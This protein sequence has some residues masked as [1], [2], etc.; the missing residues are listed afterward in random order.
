MKENYVSDGLKFPFCRNNLKFWR[1]KCKYRGLGIV[2]VSSEGPKNSIINLLQ[3][4][5]LSNKWQVAP[6]IIE[7]IFKAYMPE[8]RKSSFLILFLDKTPQFVRQQQNIVMR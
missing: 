4:K 5:R 7:L 8:Y 2:K 6:Q 1:L 3:E